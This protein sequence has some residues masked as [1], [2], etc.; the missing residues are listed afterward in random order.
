M[1]ETRAQDTAIPEKGAP[2]ARAPG[3]G[4]VVFLVDGSSFVFRAYFQSMNQDRK[5]NYRADGL[6]TGAVRLFCNKL[7]QFIRDGAADVRPTHLAIVFDK[8]EHSFRNDLYADYK[9][10]RS[11]APDDLVPQ[12]PLMRAA[13]EAFGLTP[14]EKAGYEAD[15]II[16]TYAR[17]A[18]EGGAEVVIV[19]ADKDLMQLVNGQVSMYDPA[20]GEGRRAGSGKAGV[21][22]ERR[23]GVDE[24]VDYFGVP[25]ERVVDVQALV[26]DTTDNVPGVPGIGKKTA[27]QLIEAFG[28]LDTLLSEAGTIKQPKRRENLLAHADQARLSRTLVTLDDHV[29]LDAP[30]DALVVRPVEPERLVS[31]FKALDFGTLTRRVAEDHDVAHADVAPDPRYLDFDGN[32]G[33]VA[34]DA[35]ADDEAETATPETLAVAMEKDAAAHPFDHHAYATIT[36]EAELARWIDAAREAGRLAIAV[37]T[38][39][40][41]P[42]RSG[43]A[44]IALAV[45]AGKAAYVPFAHDG[46]DLMDGGGKDG[47]LKDGSAED[48]GDGNRL[49][50]ERVLERLAPILA[51]RG[52]AKLSCQ[53]KRDVLALHRAGVTVTPVDDT[54]LLSYAAD[55]GAGQHDPAGLSKRYLN[56]APLDD[57]DVMGTGRSRIA[58]GAVPVEAATRHAAEEADM[59]VRLVPLLRQRLVAKRIST[60]YETLERPLLP[61]LA[62]MEATGLVVDRDVL[63][64]MSSDFEQTLARIEEEIYELAGERFNIGSTKQLSEIM[65]AKLGLPGG[66]KTKTGAWSTGAQVLEDLAAEGY[67]LP[68]KLLEWRQI[69]KL[70]STYTDALQEDINPETGRVHTTFTMASTTTGRLSSADPNLQ[71]IPIRTEA[72]RKIRT[73]F[74]AAPGT[75]LV[76]ADYGQIELRVLAHIAEIPQLVQAFA[77][78]LDIH[79]MTASE[80]FGV[81]VDGM[82][83]SV[84]RRAKAINFGIIYGISAYG[85]ANQLAIPREE[86][87]AY[88]KRYF[89]RFPGI[90][91]YMDRMKAFVHENGYVTTLFGRRA[92]YP[93]IDTKNPSLRAFYERAAINAPIQGSAADIIRR[94]MVRIEPALHAAG[95]SSRMTLQVH[96]ELLFEVP[97]EETERTIEVVSSVMRGAAEPAVKLKVPLDVDARAGASWSQA[98]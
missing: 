68:V 77:D 5:Y 66:K 21:R 42:M 33:A 24:V 46:H 16:A 26:G 54:G 83:P 44:G 58:F 62:R 53:M 34:A 93:E 80:M 48:G 74:V 38:V 28:D 10:N 92:H 79:A 71:N 60:V 72:G 91:D 31:F 22:P 37:R 87:S 3:P 96:D 36:T 1:T 64:R 39:A 47:G 98:H 94:A 95:L 73:A 8:S 78:G 13:V 59:A 90:R 88:I 51:D 32:T 65:F 20:S 40:G 63:S 56:H 70:K 86:A 2:D 97:M 69:S 7:Y 12:F 35:I 76:A 85:L 61:V 52:I 9:A 6:P 57:R 41:P 29:D 15:D 43:L 4:D 75:E 11:E 27:A 23:I 18:S 30:L 45:H 84:R 67:P 19:S 17:E 82:D 89:E 50:A 81:P 55:A 14:I 49:D 25:P